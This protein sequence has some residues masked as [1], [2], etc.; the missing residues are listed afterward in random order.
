MRYHIHDGINDADA[1]LFPLGKRLTLSLEC[2]ACSIPL[3]ISEVRAVVH[4]HEHR[5][6]IPHTYS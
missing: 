2:N 6:N 3:F 1:C 5:S 4:W